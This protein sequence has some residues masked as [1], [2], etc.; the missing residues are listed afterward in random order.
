MTVRTSAKS[1]LMRP[2]PRNELGDALNPRPCST[3]FAALKASSNVVLLPSTAS[4]FWF[5]MVMS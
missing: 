2:G 1:T 5:G 3:V 4:N